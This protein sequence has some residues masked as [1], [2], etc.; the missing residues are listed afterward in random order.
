MISKVEI[1]QPTRYDRP[2]DDQA[3]ADAIPIV[4][5]DTYHL[6]HLSTPKNTIHH[7]PRLRSCWSHLRSQDLIN[8]TRDTEA[9]LEP[10]KSSTSPSADGAWTGSAIE[11]PDSRLHIF[12]TGYNISQGGKQVILH[13][14]SSNRHGD[15]FQTSEKPISIRTASASPSLFDDIDFRDP[16]VFFNAEE[17]KYWM[18]VATRLTNGPY[19]TRGCIALL[20]SSNLSEWFIEPDPLYAPNDMFCPECPEM[21]TLPNGKW[22]LVYSR[23]AAP[24][25]G[26]VYRVADSPR[27]PFRTPRDGSGGRF[28]GRRWYAAKSCP[29]V[30]DQSKRIYFG[31]IGDFNVSDRKWLWGGNMAAPR[32]VFAD[33]EGHLRIE[34]VQTVLDRTY[35]ERALCSPDSH[36]ALSS[37]GSTRHRFIPMP[38]GCGDKGYAFQFRIDSV[39]ARSFGVLFC[40]DDDLRGHRLRFEVLG[41]DMYNV[42]LLTDVAPL[43]DFWADQYKLYVARGVD[44]PELVRHDRVVIKSRVTVVRAGDRLEVFCGGKS[45]SSRVVSSAATGGPK[46]SEVHELGYFAEDGEVSLGDVAMQFEQR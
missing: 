4:I 39:D 19:W 37:C 27:G 26:T 15:D 45:I 29:M 9:A 34:P 1:A 18:L 20:T 41:N 33:S 5:D 46:R 28:D 12:S 36:L 25:A 44:G 31:W 40:C 13:S 30:D 32:E 38:A 11:G 24:D 8:W 6:F 43:D 42:S 22:Y 16:Y 14:I 35:P 3:A 7:P 10:G 17:G 21:F 2:A 23:F